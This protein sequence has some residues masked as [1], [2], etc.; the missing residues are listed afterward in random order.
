M[1]LF[2]EE[3][4]VITN[5]LT[6][7]IAIWYNCISHTIKVEQYLIASC[8]ASIIVS[9]RDHQLCLKEKLCK[10]HRLIHRWQER[11]HYIRFILSNILYSFKY[12]SFLIPQFWYKLIIHTML[13]KIRLIELI[14]YVCY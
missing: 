12:A 9:F 8:N 1:H 7:T 5:K 10:A 11:N 6:L 3:W 14:L 2:A 13:T 4:K